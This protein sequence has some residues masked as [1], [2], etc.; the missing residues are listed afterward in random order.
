MGDPQA[1]PALTKALFIQAIFN[2]VRE[3]LTRVGKPSIDPMIALVQE[4]DQAIN[5]MF[6]TKGWDTKD[7][8]G[9]VQQKFPGNKINKAAQI[10]GDLK[11][12]KSV[13]VLLGLLKDP[14]KSNGHA[15]VMQ[16]LRAIDDPTSAPALRA[17]YLDKNND[18][19]LKALAID[20]FSMVSPDSPPTE[21]LDY[22]DGK[23]PTDDPD[24]KQNMMTYSLIAYGRL[25]RTKAD[26]AAV[27]DR[28]KQW[29]AKVDGFKA[30]V[31]A[32]KKDSPEQQQAQ[33]DLDSATNMLGMWTDAKSSIDVAIECTDKADCYTKYLN[34]PKNP[35]PNKPDPGLPKAIRS[36]LELARLGQKAQT[37]LD[38]LLTAAGSPQR[39]IREGVFI[40]LPRVAPTPCQKCV[41][42]LEKI[43]DQQKDDTT[44][45]LLVAETR[46]SDNYFLGANK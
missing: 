2:Q 14:K 25:G 37:A 43:I 44:L 23:V 41:E 22:A 18:D 35:D 30:K 39:L 8:D 36:L 33:N 42:K 7:K 24:I 12:V 21:L 9:N 11:A 34:P 27:E 46:I 17:Y 3:A 38:G 20:V 15:G 29:Q 40:A 32:A 45:S 13:P 5:E 10:L 1:I 16:A 31:A 19:G 4:Q 26:E 6:V 28:L